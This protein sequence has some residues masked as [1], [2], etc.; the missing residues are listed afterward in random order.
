MPQP[1]PA[2]ETFERF[3]LRSM[4]VATTVFACMATVAG[5]TY[6]WASPEL[7]T[8][9]IVCWVGLLILGPPLAYYHQRK[10]RLIVQQAGGAVHE[11]AF[12]VAAP[13]RL[14]NRSK[15]RH[16]PR[17]LSYLTIRLC[18][19]VAVSPF[20]LLA[21]HKFTY[22]DAVLRAAGID[23]LFYWLWFIFFTYIR[24]TWAYNVVNWFAEAVC[25]YLR[26]GRELLLCPDGIVH[27][28]RLLAWNKIKRIQ[29][30]SNAPSKRQI[31][32][33]HFYSFSFEVPE[34]RREAID[35]Y[36]ADRLAEAHQP[37]AA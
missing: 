19:G 37:D 17:S 10:R 15:T 24:L 14:L 23:A 8:Y 5:Y 25:A 13:R 21:I 6:R 26:H 1:D 4:F 18:L 12:D 3:S 31:V 36:I 35:A 34:D 7:Q 29:P 2:A 32:L 33:P 16:K 28:E 20:L 30:V 27:G 22:E 11:L 9:M